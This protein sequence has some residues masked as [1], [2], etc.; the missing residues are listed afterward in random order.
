M[1][2]F[3]PTRRDKLRHGRFRR[4]SPEAPGIGKGERKT[5]IKKHL[6]AAALLAFA[7]P[8]AAA[9]AWALE[10]TEL[11]PVGSAV[12]IELDTDGVM[13]V[14]L[15]EVATAEGPVSPAERA[16]LQTGDVIRAVDG[17]ATPS[18]AVFLTLMSSLDGGEHV[19]TVRRGEGELR[20]T[21]TPAQ[22]PEGAYQMGLWLRDSVTGIGTVT[23]YDPNTGTFG[24]LGH[25]ISDTG[26][27]ELLPFATGSITGAEVV[28]V[29][30][31]APGSPGEL[32]GEFD[33]ERVLG[34]LNKNTER[35]IFGVASMEGAGA[36]LPVAGEDE[37]TLGPAII[38]SCVDGGGVREYDVEISRV[39]R[40]ASDSRFLLL[41]V[42][43]PALLAATGGIVQGMSGSPIIQN[44]KLIGAVTHVLI[45]D[46]AKGYGISIEKM[47]E[48][49]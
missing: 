43:D 9:P 20:F 35:G 19:L 3:F 16:G 6:F 34:A 47:L 8:W 29:I 37:V 41:T 4:R 45:S 27:G 32:C 21:V 1:Q 38:R 18:A 13:V 46:P 10:A 42:T 28:D 11:V 23:F 33:R 49:A 40:N 25:G 14:G 17:Q 30:R 48:A 15:S 22:N 2:G 5:Q 26:T 36:A 31:G 7:L 44:G 39:Y 24:A 12:G